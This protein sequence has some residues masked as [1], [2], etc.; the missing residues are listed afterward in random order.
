[1]KVIVCGGRDY[2]NWEMLFSVLD[3]FHEL[4]TIEELHHGA[5]RGADTMAG[6]WAERR[7]IPVVRHPAEWA[8]YGG[9]AGPI[10]NS[11]ML[12]DAAPDIVIAFKGG[13]GTADMVGKAKHAGVPVFRAEEYHAEMRARERSHKR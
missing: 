9:A 4:W 2:N 1:M 6:E 10:R 8:K 7:S 3:D 11:Y 5:A 13:R 12:R